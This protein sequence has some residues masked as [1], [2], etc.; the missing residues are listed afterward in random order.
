MD[1]GGGVVLPAGK[2]WFVR[3]DAGDTLVH[4]DF[5]MIAPLLIGPPSAPV[6]NRQ[7]GA[8]SP[9]SLGDW[10]HHLRLGAGFG[11]RF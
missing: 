8:E 2:R 11:F 4:Y 6:L 5:D 3:V 9:Y 1:W 7:P 10:K